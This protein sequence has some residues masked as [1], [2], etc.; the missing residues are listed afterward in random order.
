MTSSTSSGSPRRARAS[1][2]ASTSGAGAGG[3]SGRGTGATTG[4]GSTAVWAATASWLSA[5]MRSSTAEKLL[6]SSITGSGVTAVRSCSAS[7]TD[8]A[9]ASSD[10]GG[11]MAAGASTAAGPASGVSSISTVTSNRSLAKKP[12]TPPLRTLSAPRI[13]AS[14][15][16]S[17]RTAA[18]AASRVGP[19]NCRVGKV[20]H[21]DRFEDELLSEL[22]VGEDRQAGGHGAHQPADGGAELGG[23]DEDGRDAPLLGFLGP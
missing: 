2:G 1:K 13:L 6:R 19:S 14:G 3:R 8:S 12:A 9:S 7:L 4:S 5:V 22:G 21:S 15:P 20:H 11:V 16:S 17:A 18:R 10:S 23:A